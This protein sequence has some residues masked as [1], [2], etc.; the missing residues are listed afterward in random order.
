MFCFGPSRGFS[1]RCGSFVALWVTFS[2]TR[3]TSCRD[4]TQ[5]AHELSFHFSSQVPSAPSV[6]PSR[7]ARHTLCGSGMS[8]S[9]PASRSHPL[10][11]HTTISFRR[12]HAAQ[13]RSSPQTKTKTGGMFM[14]AQPPAST[15]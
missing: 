15:G 13:I 3:V 10:P 11:R 12:K 14:A 9:R 1:L 8:T 5:R 6:F 2:H 4:I 7:N